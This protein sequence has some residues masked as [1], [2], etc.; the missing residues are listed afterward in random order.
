M[1]LKFTLDKQQ[2]KLVIVNLNSFNY[3]TNVQFICFR[4]FS[5][6][7]LGIIEDTVPFNYFED[8]VV[9]KC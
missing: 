7:K 2:D 4:P 8:V 3:C 9:S 6:F 5:S 1:Q